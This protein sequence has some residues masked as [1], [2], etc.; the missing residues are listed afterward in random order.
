VSALLA[1]GILFAF[2]FLCCRRRRQNRQ[3]GKKGGFQLLPGK[4]DTFSD[5]EDDIHFDK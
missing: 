5:S 3:R 2:C 1:A 4:D